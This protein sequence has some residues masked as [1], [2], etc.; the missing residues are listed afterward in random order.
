MK[1]FTF[2]LKKFPLDHAIKQMKIAVKT[3]KPYV[4]TGVM[5][6][7]SFD[8]MM[9]TMTASRFEAFLA[10]AEKKP[11]SI[12]A[13]AKLLNKDTSNVLRDVRVLADLK[14]I[15]L[16]EV[17]NGERISFKPVALYDTIVFECES[18]AEK[19]ASNQ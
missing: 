16:I 19:K 14:I 6:C 4:H 10:I 8:S 15:E 3:N 1:T 11:A 9:R 5:Y 7:D 13:L 2:K 12:S 17:P 18:K